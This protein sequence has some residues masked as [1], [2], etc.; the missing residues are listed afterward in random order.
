MRGV[1]F[2]LCGRGTNKRE[3][4]EDEARKA[5]F[6]VRAYL[7]RCTNKYYCI[8]RGGGGGEEEELASSSF[9]EGDRNQQRNDKS[10]LK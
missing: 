2:F 6:A 4:G 1:F 3:G 8:V 10:Q 9:A 7:P 5:V